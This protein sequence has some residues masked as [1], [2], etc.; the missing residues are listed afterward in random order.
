MRV[1]VT[2]ASGLI[3][4]NLCDRLLA[5][6]DEVVAL[7]RNPEAAATTNPTVSWHGWSSTT[8]RPPVEA[9]EGIDAVVNLV[10]EPIDQRHTPEAKARIMES[11]ERST[12]NL[13]DGLAAAPVK[14]GVLV[15]QSATGYYGD[16][17]EAIVD[18]STP[19]GSDFL[20]EVCSR[21]EAAAQPAAAAGIRLVNTRTGLVLDPSGGLLKQLLLPFKLGVGGPLAGGGWYM[22]WIHRD[23]EVGLMLWAI[24]NPAAQG[25]FNS[26][27]P[28]P[29]T[30]REFSKAL[31]RALHR[32]SFAP[33]PK[34]AVTA[35]LGREMADHATASIRAVPRRAQDKGYVFRH[36]E[37]GEALADLVG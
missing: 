25:V 37:V 19:A 17:G 18:E 1:L 27:A 29:V 23:D 8:E 35:R 36:P 14:P 2:G 32:P 24:D 20:A 28:N 26:A 10:G 31:G 15:S 33:V 30:N 34:L 7:S 11:R 6:G 13:V 16:H 5:R 21:W 4:M 9:L 22:P 3:G 12:K